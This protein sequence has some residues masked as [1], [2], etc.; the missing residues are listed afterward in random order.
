M[1]KVLC[2]VMV[3]AGLAGC[4]TVKEVSA[5][6]KRPA[7]MTAYAADPRADCGPMQRVNADADAALL[8]IQAMAE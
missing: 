6:C 4:G 5:P 1:N 8:A 3:A 7:N 2:I